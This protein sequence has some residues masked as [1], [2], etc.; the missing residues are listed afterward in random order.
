MKITFNKKSLTDAIS[1]LMVA[2][3]SKSVSLVTEGILITAE[4]GENT[5]TMNAYDMEKGVRVIIDAEVIEGGSYIISAQKL[6]GI[7]R[8]MP[9]EE[10][11]LKVDDKNTVTVTGGRSMFRLHAL[12][13]SD[14][15]GLPVLSGDKGFYIKE[16]DLKNLINRVLF[17]VDV[18]NPMPALNGV[19]FE[20]E[21]NTIKIIGCDGKSFAMCDKVCDLQNKS[22]GAINFKFIVPVK[23]ATELVKMLSDGEDTVLLELTRKH[24]IFKL[25]ETVLFSR[26][27]DQE[28]LD[29]NRL[30]PTEAK[31]T[32]TAN[33]ADIVD[34]LERASLVTEEKIA[35]S[36]RSYVKLS[37]I[38]NILMVTSDSVTGSVKDEIAIFHRG[39]DLD[40]GFNCRYLLD[41][42]RACGDEDVE[43]RLNSSLMPM[44]FS[45]IN[46]KE[47]DNFLYFVL[48]LR[49]KEQ[50]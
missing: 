26:M 32:A 50:A 30:I 33:A 28:Y 14:F 23:T 35:G 13:G 18:G 19:Y 49:M 31:I 40:I 36:V 5:V 41:A 34:A 37:F 47:D 6:L 42:F 10:I 44:A 11:D 20:I 15:P 27:I 43:I 38:G 9:G 24:I 46:P 12:N 22:E 3:T 8:T 17:A 25:D 39:D 21:G 7:V 2:V 4:T 29:Y 45:P 16:K 1:Q 48:P